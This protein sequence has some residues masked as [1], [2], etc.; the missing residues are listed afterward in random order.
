[1]YFDL[2]MMN[3]LLDNN[4]VAEK[5]ERETETERE[6]NRERET[7]RG[8]NE[9]L[10]S[11]ITCAGAYYMDCRLPCRL[12]NEAPLSLFPLVFFFGD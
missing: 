12:C 11:G 9:T 2:K 1:M 3:K 8:G 7:G 6:T 5:V 4:I 10:S